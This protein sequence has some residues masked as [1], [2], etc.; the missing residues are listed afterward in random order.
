MDG[1]YNGDIVVIGGNIDLWI[2]KVNTERLFWGI[3]RWIEL[4]AGGLWSSECG[5]VIEREYVITLII[6]VVIE[7]RW[8]NVIVG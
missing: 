3:V 1:V 7:V 4:I 2:V 8:G 5:R 6:V